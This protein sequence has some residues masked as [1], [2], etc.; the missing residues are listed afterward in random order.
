MRPMVDIANMRFGSLIAITPVGK[1]AGRNI[2]WEC[3]CDC[4]NITYRTVKQLR[5]SL[6][7]SCGCMSRISIS[8]AK[9][10][11]GECSTRLYRIWKSM[12]Q[13]VSHRENW[14]NRGITI[15]TEWDNYMVF[16]EWALSH[17]YTDNLSIDRID[18]NGNYTPE[19]CRW[20]TAKEQANNRRPPRKRTKE[21][22]EK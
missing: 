5:D 6:F 18:N 1:S 12:R 16:R 14:H 11:H 10:K 15:C 7:P 9:T 21:G 22:V 3:Q 8:K 20:A 2:I 19:N 4:G 17:G 13:R